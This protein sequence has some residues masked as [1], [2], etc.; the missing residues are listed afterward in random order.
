[1]YQSNPYQQ[2]NQQQQ[3]QVHMQEQD[4]ANFVLSELKRSAG[5]YATAAT[6]AVNPQIRQTFQTLL[7]KTLQDHA[8]LF[9]EIQ[10]L[11]YYEVQAVSQQ[12]IQHELQKQSQTAAQLQSFVQQNLNG[13]S[14]SISYQSQESMG[15]SHQQQSQHQNEIAALHQ[16]PIQPMITTS[17]YPNAV[18]NNQGQGYSPTNQHQTYSTGQG[19]QNTQDYQSYGQSSYGSSQGY[20]AS[21]GYNTSASTS[22][23]AGMIG[24]SANPSIASRQSSNP[25]GES[26]YMN[27]QHEGSKYSF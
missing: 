5:E 2:Q 17:Q 16:A 18:Y 24:K 7:Q 15:V 13:T 9:Q 19:Q 3:H 21:T 10:N 11:G 20:A 14:S 23:N 22:D 25:T 27:K 4:F 1:M 12:Q 26:S 6:E 8:I